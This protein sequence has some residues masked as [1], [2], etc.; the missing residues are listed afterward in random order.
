MG[1]YNII[2]AHDS[3]G[4]SLADDPLPVL[5]NNLTRGTASGASLPTLFTNQATQLT[6]Q[7]P[8]H[9]TSVVKT[10]E[11]SDYGFRL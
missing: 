3:N 1:P 4:I 2:Q 11:R 9:A 5:P 10:P 6:T 8:K 7:K